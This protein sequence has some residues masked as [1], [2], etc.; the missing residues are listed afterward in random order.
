MTFFIRFVEGTSSGTGDSGEFCTV[1]CFRR[2]GYGDGLICNEDYWSVLHV[3][4]GSMIVLRFAR[5]PD[6]TQSFEDIKKPHLGRAALDRYA[7]RDDLSGLF[8]GYKGG[9]I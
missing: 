9:P 6:I 7:K 4:E 5:L 2:I 3:L 8:A 1:D